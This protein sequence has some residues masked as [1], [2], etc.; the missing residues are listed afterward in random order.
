ML[1]SSC[2]AECLFQAVFD[3]LRSLTVDVAQPKMME[4][5]KSAYMLHIHHILPPSSSHTCYLFVC[6]GT[7]QVNSF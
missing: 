1:L 3:P 4:N 6:I 2:I 5:G 7:Q